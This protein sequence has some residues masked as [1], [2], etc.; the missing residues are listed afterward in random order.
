MEAAGK[1]A[2][3]VVPVADVS[4]VDRNQPPGESGGL[5]AA[6]SDANGAVEIASSLCPR[7]RGAEVAMKPPE[8]SMSA[9]PRPE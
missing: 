3:A 5:L 2:V 4:D 8:D 6:G 1:R 7:Q 9:T